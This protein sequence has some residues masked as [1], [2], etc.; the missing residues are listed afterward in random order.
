M[1]VPRLTDT[2]MA[3]LYEEISAA[4]VR[5]GYHALVATSHD[6]PELERENGSM[7]LGRRVDGLILT[8]AR[9]DGGF[10]QDLLAR[11]VPHVLAV[12]TFGESVAAVGDDRLGGYLA[13]RHL[14]DLGHRRIGLIAG[15]DHASS[16]LGRRAGYEDALRE[17]GLAVAPEL[18]YPS[19]FSMESGE[20]AGGLLLA[21]EPRPTAVFA[22]NDD[23]AV[24]LLSAVQ[25]AGLRVPRDLSVVG[26][27][28][29]PLAARLP[30]PL[31]TVRVPFA[32]IA[33][34]A[35]EQLVQIEAGLPAVT[36]RFAPTLIPRGSTARYR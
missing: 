16:A 14:L 15:P 21:T 26:Y 22:V 36:R 33:D 31:T 20:D 28:D 8:T 12:R 1:L 34:A 5:R 13:T 19:S 27:N 6:D 32:E 4:C 2:V 9:V 11:G 23:T 18:I 17:A 7:L 29:I 24:G 30:V 10:C 3:M 25:R 35:V